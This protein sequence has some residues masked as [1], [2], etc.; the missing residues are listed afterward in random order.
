MKKRV[1][2]SGNIRQGQPPP[3]LHVY[4][5]VRVDGWFRFIRFHLY[6]KSVVPS[7]YDGT[8]RIHAPPGPR[9]ILHL[10]SQL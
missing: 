3:L 2:V 4:T 10:T 1:S 5:G 8:V 6:T 7:V 9:V